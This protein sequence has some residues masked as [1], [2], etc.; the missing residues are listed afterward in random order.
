MRKIIVG[1]GNPGLQYDRTRHNAGFLFLDELADQLDLKFQLL[2]KTRAGIAK[3]NHWLLIKP[4]TFMNLSGEAVRATLAYYSI[5]LGPQPQNPTNKLLLVH[6]DLDLK[7]GKFKF[8]FA[9][10]PQNHYGVASVEAQL[11]TTQFWRLRLGIDQRLVSGQPSGAE[12]VLAQ[13]N[14]EE[15]C[16]VKQTIKETVHLLLSGKSPF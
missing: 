9:K 7:L 4:Q 14:Q 5:D 12:Y 6:D 15:L 16:L 11:K 8:A 2:K 1:L 10:S 3:N 13:F